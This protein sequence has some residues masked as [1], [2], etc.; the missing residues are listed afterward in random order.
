MRASR[1]APLLSSARQSWATPEEI[2]ARLARMG[3]VGLDPCSNAES[4]IA[5][6][7]RF[8]GPPS[9]RPMRW[10]RVRGLRRILGEIDGLRRSWAGFGLVYV[11]SEYGRALPVWQAKCVLE[12]RARVEIVALVPA[13]PDTSWWQDFTTTADKVC[14]WRGRLRFRGARHPAPFPSA[15]AYWGPRPSR[16]VAAF[17]D[18]GWIPTERVRQLALTV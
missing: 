10:R 16:F 8:Y 18:A 3:P 1:L 17:G 5:A 6:A 9:L 11:N 14:F 13:R 4:I 12:A 15:L 7:R 2:A